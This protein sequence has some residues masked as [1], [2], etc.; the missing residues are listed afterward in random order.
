MTPQRPCWALHRPCY[1]HVQPHSRS[2]AARYYSDQLWSLLAPPVAPNSFTFLFHTTAVRTLL[3]LFTHARI[4]SFNV[5]ALSNAFKPLH[6]LHQHQHRTQT[7]DQ[8]LFI[9]LLTSSFHETTPFPNVYFISSLPNHLGP[10]I[11]TIA[12]LGV[13]AAFLASFSTS[14]LI[15]KLF[16]GTHSHPIQLYHHHLR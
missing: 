2:H 1:G 16:Q 3:H 4:V 8:Q 7:T 10:R 11:N 5:F 12:N 6:Q 13:I 14:F 9:I 15:Q